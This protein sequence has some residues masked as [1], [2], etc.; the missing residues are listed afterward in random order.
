MGSGRGRGL[1]MGG[2]V[3]KG[4]SIQPLG[5]CPVWGI[6]C[7]WVL[8]S[9][10]SIIVLWRSFFPFAST[11][12]G[13]FLARRGARACCMGRVCPGGVPLLVRSACGFGAGVSAAFGGVAGE[14]LHRIH[15]RI[16][17]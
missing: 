10:S 4:V 2:W 15:V 16:G 9:A 8:E 5:G 11:C 1:G 17:P 13:H 12:V 14:G 6:L 3:E 7:C